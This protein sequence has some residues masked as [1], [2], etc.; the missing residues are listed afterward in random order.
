MEH[1]NQITNSEISYNSD[2]VSNVTAGESE[3]ASEKEGEPEEESGTES[4]V[5][6][7]IDV[8]LRQA[9]N[10]AYDDYALVNFNIFVHS[11]N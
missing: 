5:E 11:Q 3:E 9:A 10:L 1:L 8:V 2:E 4:D 6:S 7:G